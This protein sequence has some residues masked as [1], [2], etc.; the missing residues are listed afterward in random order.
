[1]DPGI[2]GNP[3]T[4]I[5]PVY[6]TGDFLPRCLDSLLGQTFRDF[7]V[8]CVDDGSTDGSGK[9]L[10]EYSEKDSRIKVVHLQKNHGVP[11]GRNLALDSVSGS[12]YVYFMDSDDWIDPDYL[13]AMYAA[14][15]RTGQDVVI[16]AN[17]YTEYDNPPRSVPSG[18]YGFINERPGYYSPL[19]IQKYFFPVVWTRLYRL[20]YLNDNNIRSPLLKGGVEDNYFTA[21]AEILQE[22]SYIF[23]GPFYHYWQR[24]GSLVTQPGAGF[25]H[26]ENFRVFVDE[27]RSRGLPPG[28][29]RL[30][31]VLK[32]LVIEDESQFEFIHA[33]FKDV[34]EEVRAFPKH[35][36]S[37]DVFCML[38]VLSCDSY[39][40]WLAKY[41][42]SVYLNFLRIMKALG[43][44]PSTEAMLRGEQPV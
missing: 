20:K 19:L 11:Y 6:N 21:L 30:F 17:W 32:K 35:Y 41:S 40:E 31:Y 18:R 36:D 1:M 27:I 43:D 39:Q 14:A 37:L 23:C 24:P 3:I 4:V 26:F 15:L 28:S 33:F 8:F 42:P 5:L 34:E 2:M 7:D 44:Y 10:D 9:I 25:R 22:R 12:E 29:A 16:N 38:S 13:E